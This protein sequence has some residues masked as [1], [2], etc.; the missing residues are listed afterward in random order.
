MDNKGKNDQFEIIYDDHDPEKPKGKPKPRQ[1]ALPI[2]LIA[3]GML[4]SLAIA[5]VIA[6]ARI[7]GSVQ[8]VEQ[9][10]SSLQTTPPSTATYKSEPVYDLAWSPDGTILAVYSQSGVR[11][12]AAPFQTAPKILRV[13]SANADEIAFSPDG[14]QIAAIYHTYD[15][16]KSNSIT[17]YVSLWDVST[18]EQ[19]R[20]FQ[21]KDAW[22]K[23][24]AF[25]LDGTQLAATDNLGHVLVWDSQIGTLTNEFQH[26]L[27]DN[28][29]DLEFDGQGRLL[30]AGRKVVTDGSTNEG[31]Y[32]QSWDL[33]GAG[34]QSETKLNDLPIQ[35][36]V[37]GDAGK[38]LAML[39]EQGIE[40]W[41]LDWGMQEGSIDLPA[42]G[43][44]YAAQFGGEPFRIGVVSFVH[45]P[46]EPTTKFFVRIWSVPDG[47][48]LQSRPI[49]DN[50][51]ML[52]AL[53]TDLTRL[54]TASNDG[55][56]RIRDSAT[57]RI[58]KQ[59]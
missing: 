7:T 49:D 27:G 58:I 33:R 8:R 21:G 26:N 51:I 6:F 1:D 48:L 24:I 39:H 46:T 52:A 54:A 55:V 45:T 40:L 41:N 47:E 44:A 34:P 14:S 42:L 43:Q 57:G 16:S 15:P 4:M 3:G 36:Q 18:G 35:G 9:S 12:H 32:F 38:W 25:N 10:Q 13:Q 37:F 29:D 2:I 50:N 11:L 19:K 56:V 17:G 31:G 23:K 20:I 28:I 30:A 59:L 53:N 22:I 5:G